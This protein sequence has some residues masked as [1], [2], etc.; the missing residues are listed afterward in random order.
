MHGLSPRQGKK[1]LRGIFDLIF[2]GWAGIGLVVLGWGLPRTHAVS[3]A[4]G[5]QL[6]TLEAGRTHHHQVTE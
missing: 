3:G 6:L 1:L 2:D 5:L 4:A